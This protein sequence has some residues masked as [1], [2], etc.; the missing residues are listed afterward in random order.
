[1]V[2]RASPRALRTTIFTRRG[3]FRGTILPLKASGHTF[4]DE[5]DTLPIGWDHVELRVDAR[6]NSRAD[7]VAL[8]IEIGDIVAI[9]PQPEFEENG[10]IVLAPPRQQGGR[11]R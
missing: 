5:V 7:L 4:G 2:G 3:A 6:A 11:R 1:M 9:D 8:G 10:Y